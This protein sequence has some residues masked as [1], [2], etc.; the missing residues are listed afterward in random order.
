M[1]TPVLSPFQDNLKEK[2]GILKIPL[3]ETCEKYVKHGK[4]VN[5]L[6]YKLSLFANRTKSLLYCHKKLN[7]KNAGMDS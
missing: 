1:A 5:S 2:P 6:V 4:T 7:W 3:L